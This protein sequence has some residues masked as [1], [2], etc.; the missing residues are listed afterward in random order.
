M[1]ILLRVLFCLRELLAPDFH[2]KNFMTERRSWSKSFRERFFNE[3]EERRDL[4]LKEWSKRNILE[5]FFLNEEDERWYWIIDRKWNIT[6]GFV[7]KNK[8]GMKW[9]RN[10]IK[11]G[12][13]FSYDLDE[14]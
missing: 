13:I 9:R 10:E 2:E 6:R 11:I 7:F 4:N 12:E 8:K 5:T 3:E 14:F 1:R